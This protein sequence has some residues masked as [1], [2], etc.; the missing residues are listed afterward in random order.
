MVH[1]PTAYACEQQ[2]SF[3]SL[4]DRGGGSEE[5]IPML[6]ILGLSLVPFFSF[7]KS[8]IFCL[9]KNLLSAL[10]YDQL[11]YLLVF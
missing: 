8:R 5:V 9:S 4:L 10:L 11:H 7:I 3:T 6:K 1:F 2:E